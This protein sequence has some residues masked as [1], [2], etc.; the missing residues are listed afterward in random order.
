[1]VLDR[2]VLFHF[3]IELFKFLNDSP[4]LGTPGSRLKLLG[5]EHCSNSIKIGALATR[6]KVEFSRN[7]E[8]CAGL[9]FIC[10][11]LILLQIIDNYVTNN[12]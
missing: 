6:E 3:F 12:L 2:F 1:M 10:I 7:K 9:N 11:N 5:W 8:I 4:V